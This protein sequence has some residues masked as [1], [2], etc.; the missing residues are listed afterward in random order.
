[1]RNPSNKKSSYSTG[2]ECVRQGSLS[3][4]SP[5]RLTVKEIRNNNSMSIWINKSESVDT[6]VNDKG[7]VC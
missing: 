4:I 6:C 1:M 5:T 3:P 2:S 7:K